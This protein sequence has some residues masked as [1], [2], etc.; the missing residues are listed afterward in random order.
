M[1]DS[2]ILDQKVQPNENSKPEVA[3]VSSKQVQINKLDLNK[4]GEIQKLQ[5]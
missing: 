3:I 4:V 1:E 5:A 2:S